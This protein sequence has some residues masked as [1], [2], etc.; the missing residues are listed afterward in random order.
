MGRRTVRLTLDTLPDIPSSCATCLFWELDP[1]RRNAACGHERDEKAAW[2][3]HALREWGSVGRVL[4]VDDAYAGHAIWAPEIYV[5]GTA[6]FATAPVSP[7]AVVLVT[8]NVA[9]RYRGGGLGR[10][11][12]Q[13]M[14]KDLIKRGGIR[15]V[16]A[17]GDTRGRSGHCVLPAD[18]LLAVGFAT[19][20]AHATYPRMRM[21]LR[22]AVTWRAEIEQALSKLLPHPRRVPGVVAPGHSRGPG[23]V[24]PV[25][26][27][28]TPRDAGPAGPARRV[29]PAPR[30]AR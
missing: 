8:A 12:I 7:D 17:F 23:V 22:S 4:Y 1:V 3:S 24:P 29:P 9:A 26:P 28:V 10:V 15:A 13:S 5:P 27:R 16:E 30:G 11:L 6:G 21:E 14:A 18:F 19:H 2:L 25:T 20:R